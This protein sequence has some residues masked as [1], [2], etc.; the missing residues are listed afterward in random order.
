MDITTLRPRR[1]PRLSWPREHGGY[2]TVLG[3]TLAA[4][5]G[6]PAAGPAAGV[7]LALAAGFF[8]RGAVDRLA[9]GA[10]LRRWD[11][12]ALAVAGALALAGLGL[13][14]SQRPAPAAAVGIVIVAMLVASAVA[15]RRRR[16]RSAA[17]ELAGMAAMGASAGLGAAAGDAPLGAAA[18]L[19]VIVGTHAA[20]SV[21]LVRTALRPQERAATSRALAAAALAL[22]AGAVLVAALG[23]PRAAWAFAPRAVELAWRAARPGEGHD[24][25]APVRVGLRE[26]VHLAVVATIS[27]IGV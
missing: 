7:G 1:A 17:F 18:A 14:G 19:A 6:A 26:A 27:A 12:A 23:R 15:R 5:L 24:R 9:I 20:V 4:V 25:P 21:P 11:G 13:V 3:A 8:A 10:P 16:Q 2:L 22:V